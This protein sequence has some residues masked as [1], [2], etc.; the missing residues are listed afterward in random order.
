MDL[1][2]LS[3]RLSRTKTITVIIINPFLR[4]LEGPFRNPRF[5]GLVQKIYWFKPHIKNGK[6][7]LVS[8]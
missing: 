4:T 7:G 2:T 8:G 3:L 1:R 5:N 6:I